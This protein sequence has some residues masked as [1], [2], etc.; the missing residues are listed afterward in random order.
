MSIRLPV[1]SEPDFTLRFWEKFDGIEE[2]AE[3]L[4]RG[5]IEQIHDCEG[6]F[7][8]IIK[9]ERVYAPA[10]QFH[11]GSLFESDCSLTVKDSLGNVGAL[12]E[13]ANHRATDRVQSW[14]LV[15]DT[16]AVTICA[17]RVYEAC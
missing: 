5:I 17:G 12:S 7:I 16:Y 11:R 15:H 3:L 14:P 4:R 1:L 8:G 13:T 10:E 9:P 2:A 6:N